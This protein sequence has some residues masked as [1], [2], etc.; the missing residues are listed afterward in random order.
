MDVPLEQLPKIWQEKIRGLEM[1]VRVLEIKL[2]LQR[3]ERFGPS[4]EKLS[5][6]QL[7]LLEQELSVTEAEVATEAAQAQA[8]STLPVPQPKLRVHPGRTQLPEA[9]E[10]REVV[11]ACSTEDRQCPHCQKEKAVIGY[12]VSEELASEPVVYFVRVTKREKRACHH[13]PEAGVSTAPCPPKIIPKGKLGNEL[14]IDALLNKFDAHIPLYRQC[15]ML[16]R[17]TGIELS[18]QTLTEAVIAAGQLMQPMRRLLAENLKA[19]GYIQADETP[20]PCQ[21][22]RSP[23]RHHQ[24]YM[25]EYSRPAGPVVFD[26]RMGRQRD[27][28]RD[29]LKGFVGDLQTDGYAAYDDLGEGIIHSGCLS[30]AR[31]GFHKAHLVAKN[32]PLP[33]EV[34]GH[35]AHLYRIEEEARAARMSFEQRLAL[36]QQRSRPIMQQLKERIVAIRQTV[37]PQSALGKACDYALRQWQRLCVFLENGRIEIDNNLCENA[38]RPI[39]L[40]RK[41]WLHIGS[42]A[43]G[44]KIAAIMSVME[45]CRRLGINVRDYFNDILPKLAEWPM[46]RVGQLTPMAWQSARAH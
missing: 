37:L 7:Q 17:D 14:V 42:E 1:Q 13:C 19:G 41:N 21:S 38:I 8:P 27:G 29:F 12:E 4:S 44:P 32:D 40:G 26:F 5:D 43:A 39:A 34:L 11:I 6:Q 9:L 46:S 25:W 35:I 3:I 18:R 16:K 23:G 10:R 45:T 31:R 2:R 15:A 24:A 33:L 20:V 28:P 30:H 36:R 22:E